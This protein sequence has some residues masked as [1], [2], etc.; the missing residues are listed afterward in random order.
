MRYYY[1]IILQ[2]ILYSTTLAHAQEIPH[3]DDMSPGAVYTSGDRRSSAPYI[4]GDSFRAGC[5]FAFDELNDRVDFSKMQKGSTIFVN[6]D[7]L[8][9]FFSEIH[10][11][12]PYPYIL[13]THNSDHP[14]PGRFLPHLDDDK[15]IAWFGQ[16]VS[17]F[18]RHPKLH[19]IPIGIAN[20]RWGHGN[21][22]TFQ[23]MQKDCSSLPKSIL[24]YGNFSSTTHSERGPMVDLFRNKPYCHFE[25]C[26]KNHEGYLTDLARSQ[27]V[28]SPRGNGLDCHRTWESLLMGSIP[29]VRESSL[30]PMYENLPVLIIKDWNEITEDLLKTKYEEM[31]SKNYQMDNIYI[32][33]WIDL[34]NSFK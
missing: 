15:I 16:N 2:A 12:I 23:R 34:I 30:D 21:I 17:V 8:K 13:V 20:R 19:P 25:S 4:S 9:R 29:I 27:F 22:D 6:A 11:N 7:I 10:P 31:T 26:F 1:F 14:I 5:D 28:L 24:L 3:A 32:N 33:Y 18:T